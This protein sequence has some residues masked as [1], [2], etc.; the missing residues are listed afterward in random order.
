MRHTLSTVSCVIK[1][2]PAPAARPK[3]SVEL[4]ALLGGE[5]RRVA[6]GTGYRAVLCFTATVSDICCPVLSKSVVGGGTTL[7]LAGSASD[8][9]IVTSRVRECDNADTVSFCAVIVREGS[10][11]SSPE[12]AGTEHRQF[13]GNRDEAARTGMST[14][15]W[16]LCNNLHICF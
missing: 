15:L 3:S 5:P 4:E 12:P 14:G 9:R 2:R 10:H 8:V 16:S 11:R 7:C 1:R 13:S 6:Q